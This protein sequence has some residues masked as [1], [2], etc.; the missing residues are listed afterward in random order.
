VGAQCD[1]DDPDSLQEGMIVCTG[2]ETGSVCNDD[3]D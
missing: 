2:D 3:T 1:G